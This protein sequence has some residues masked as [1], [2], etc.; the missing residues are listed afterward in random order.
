ME[1]QQ[2][3]LAFDH[4]F[5]TVRGWIVDAVEVEGWVAREAADAL[6][7]L[8][9]LTKQD[10]R[11]IDQDLHGHDV[12]WPAD[13]HV[14]LQFGLSYDRNESYRREVAAGLSDLLASMADRGRR[15][16]VTLTDALRSLAVACV[17]E[18]TATIEQAREVYSKYV[19]DGR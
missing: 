5:V 16:R 1:R 8:P 13:S 11:E 18:G 12:V 4:G 9:H 2:A 15:Q 10:R 3:I 19:P 7:A 14:R 6:G 17:A